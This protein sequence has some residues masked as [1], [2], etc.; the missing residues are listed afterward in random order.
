[1][2]KNK[3]NVLHVARRLRDLK[4]EVVFIGGGVVELLLDDNYELPLR[5]SKDVDTVVEVC[6]YGGLHDL[7]KRLRDLGFKNDQNLICRWE[8]D[9]LLVDIMP[10]DEKILGFSNRWYKELFENAVDFKLAKDITIRLVTAPF[11]LATKI[12][13]FI[14]RG[15]QDYLGSHDLDD[16]VTLIDGRE[17]LLDEISNSDLELQKY[18]QDK[19]RTV[20]AHPRFALSLEGH[21]A[22]YSSGINVRKTRVLELIDKVTGVVNG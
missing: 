3:D 8:I 6:G 17:L 21:L 22:P 4:N 14:D 10:T 16:I 2:S 15:A 1:M 13:A 7:E 18:L 9:G 20:F 19:F 12:E 11:L 5:V